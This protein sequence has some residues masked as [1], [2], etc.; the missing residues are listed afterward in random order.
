MKNGNEHEKLSGNCLEARQIKRAA[1]VLSRIVMYG[2]RRILP[3]CNKLAP[4]HCGLRS[5]LQQKPSANT[6]NYY[7]SCPP[8]L[9][10]NPKEHTA[11]S[12]FWDPF[13]SL[14]A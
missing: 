14:I 10:N 2:S 12:T 11:V 4:P 8:Q 6:H 5:V 13:G 1:L 7:V 9:Q 3:A